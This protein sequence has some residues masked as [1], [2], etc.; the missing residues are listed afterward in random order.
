ANAM[1]GRQRTSITWIGIPDYL[2]KN[3]RT[4]NIANRYYDQKGNEHFHDNKIDSYKQNHY[5]LHYNY[6]AS[7]YLNVSGTI[8]ATT[9]NGYYE[10][11][12]ENAKLSKYGIKPIQLHDTLVYDEFGDVS[13]FP[14]SMLTRTNLIRQKWLDN[15][16]YGYTAGATYNKNKITASI[17]NSYNIYDGEH[18]GYVTSLNFVPDFEKYL[19][20]SNTGKKIDLNVF[21][22]I[23]YQITNTLSIFVDAQ[24]RNITYAMHGI[25]DDLYELDSTYTWNFFNPKGG[26]FYKIDNKNSMF[27]SYAISNREPARSDLRDVREKQLFHETLYDLEFGYQYK[28]QKAAI[29]LNF[30]SMKYDN[31][32]VLTGRLNEVGA[33]IKENA[34]IDID[35]PKQLKDK[36]EY[37]HTIVKGIFKRFAVKDE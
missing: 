35:T 12:K 34:D 15:V 8:H 21:A 26:L 25:D 7:K 3:D 37:V 32:L 10:Q 20:Y 19:W 4:Y 16:F 22:K 30:Y 13:I 2:L 11:F 28:R 36:Y 17:G 33:A 24:Q 9:G 6:A 29:A 1:L 18:F 23:H 5:S 31:Q 14:D 27:I